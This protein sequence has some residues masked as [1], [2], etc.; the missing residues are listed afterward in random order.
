LTR[1]SAASLCVFRAASLGCFYH[2][3]LRQLRS[4]TSFAEHGKNNP[5]TKPAPPRMGGSGFE[6]MGGD[7]PSRTARRICVP[8][9]RLHYCSDYRSTCARCVVVLADAAAQ[10]ELE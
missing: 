6:E 9:D 4:R 7:S 2:Q 8:H 3:R 5:L 10:T 1:K